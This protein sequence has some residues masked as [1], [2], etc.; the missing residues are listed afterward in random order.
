MGKLLYVVH[1]PPPLHG[2]S[3][4]N[5]I[6]VNSAVINKNIVKKVV[7]YSY[8]T[9]LSEIGLFSLQKIY[10]FVFINL[11]ILYLIVSFRPSVVYMTI[12]PVGIGFLSQVPI[13]LLLRLFSLKVVLHIHGKGLKNYLE[14]RQLL[15]VVYSISLKGKSVIHLS[16]KLFLEDFGMFQQHLSQK[17]IVP[18]GVMVNAV[19]RKE[20]KNAD[21]LNFV[22][23]SN[24]FESKG[25]FFLFEILSA[26]GDMMDNY[27]KFVLHIVGS[28]PNDRTLDKVMKCIDDSSFDVVYH[29]PLY[30]EQK[31]QLLGEMNIAI[32]PSFNDAFPLTL[33]E[34]LGVGLPV[35]AS[36]QGAIGEIIDSKV[37]AVYET[38]NLQDALNSLDKVVE[39]YR[40]DSE[41]MILGCIG[42][43]KEHYSQSIFEQNISKT[44]KHL[45]CAE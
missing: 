7:N 41:I 31:F 11:K 35:V 29:G 44:L 37:G 30:G 19:V 23:L 36:D 45:L 10:R 12:P 9:S 6:I 43:Y 32:Y 14:N 28:C 25:I 18:N 39:K 5:N 16:D 34:F 8:S 22:F 26:Y 40:V 2:V 21:K 42:R 4:L 13:L 38:G 1:L 33:L 20:R 15:K 27:D 17:Y 3:L 24:L